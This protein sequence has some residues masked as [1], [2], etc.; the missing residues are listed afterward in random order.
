ME[1]K[2]EEEE[3]SMDA[4]LDSTRTV[5][6][7][8]EALRTE[9]KSQLNDIHMNIINDDDKEEGENKTGHNPKSFV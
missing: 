7:G 3:W 9:H 8:L 6:L 2:E 4:I 1:V 5:S